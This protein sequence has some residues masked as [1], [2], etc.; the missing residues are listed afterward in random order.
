MKFGVGIP[1]QPFRP[2]VSFMQIG[3]VT[4]VKCE[5]IYIYIYISWPILVKFGTPQGMLLVICAFGESVH[6]EG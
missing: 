2:S 5:G 4:A 1:S 6:R 3:P